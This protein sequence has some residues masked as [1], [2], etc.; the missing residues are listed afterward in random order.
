MAS[1][2][3]VL[4]FVLWVGAALVALFGRWAALGRAL[5][6]GGALSGV[7]AAIVG[8]PNPTSTAVLPLRLAG[9]TVGA[10]EAGKNQRE[11]R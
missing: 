4:S 7:I 6:A 8:L 11:R 2:M 9:E 5:L 10:H 1:G 3:L